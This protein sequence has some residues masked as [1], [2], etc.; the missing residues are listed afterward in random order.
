M[1]YFVYILYSQSRDRYYVGYSR[2]PFS[3][4]DEHNMGATTS[5]K[6]GRPWIL[7]YFE[8]CDDK[9][10]A[11]KLE[12]KIKRM[13]SRKYIESLIGKKSAG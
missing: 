6:N 9:S 3:R 1:E 11:I 4:L 10:A 8:D 5:T 7:V 2:D 12:C 13:K